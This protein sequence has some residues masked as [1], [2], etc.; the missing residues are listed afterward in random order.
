MPFITIVYTLCPTVAQELG[1]IDCYVVSTE[2]KNEAVGVHMGQYLL[3]TQVNLR[4]V[5]YVH[6]ASQWHDYD[7]TNYLPPAC[8]EFGKS[9]PN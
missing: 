9:L 4:P 1:T 2:Q 7:K 5:S 6:N 8:S 3:G